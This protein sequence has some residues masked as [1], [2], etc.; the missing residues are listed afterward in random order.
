MRKPE[1]TD[2]R[3]RAWRVRT[4]RNRAARGRPPEAGRP[5]RAARGGPPSPA[6]EPA[7]RART[8]RYFVDSDANKGY[9]SL[10]T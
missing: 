5:R 1:E 3:I 4:S 6:A 8:G 10:I 2:A 9:L 7:L